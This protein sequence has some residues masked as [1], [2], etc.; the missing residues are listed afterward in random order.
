MPDPGATSSVKSLEKEERWR[1]CLDGIRAGKTEALAQ[2]YDETSSLLYGLAL[3]VLANSSDAEEVVLDVYQHVWR[4]PQKYDPE[5][6]TLWGWLTVLTRS[7]AID[8]LRS[9][10]SRQN[11]EL[12]I[13]KGFEIRS[14]APVPEEQSVFS[15]ERDLV[16]GALETLAPEQREAIEL[17]FFRGLSHAEVAE[18]TGVPLGTIKTRIRIG[19]RK[20]R[21][22]LAPATAG[23]NP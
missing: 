15:Q 13:E 11:R 10:G 9:I 12:P 20:M 7:R 1:V 23:G 18:A 17:A 16:R 19:M 6:G 14:H 5:R 22:V 21:D 2:L 3:R 4:S 8:R